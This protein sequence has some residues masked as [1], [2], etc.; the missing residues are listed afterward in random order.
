M[1]DQELVYK[2]VK[3]IPKG[4]VLTYGVIAKIAGIKNPRQ[5]GSILHSNPDP[6]S[7]PCHRVVNFQGKIA[8]SYAFGGG[9]AQRQKLEAE[10]VEFAND[11]ID[12][13]KFL[14]R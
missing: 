2:I 8:Q 1:N 3:N 13:N 6:A 10:G 5:V 14:L 4:K 12:L 7:I 9:A 11:K